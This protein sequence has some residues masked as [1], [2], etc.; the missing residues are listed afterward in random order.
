MKS[1]VL[2]STPFSALGF[3]LLLW[4]LPPL[5][6]AISS[7]LTAKPTSAL[8]CCSPI[9]ATLLGLV[10][11]LAAAIETFSIYRYQDTAVPSWTCTS[12]TILA[13]LA[14]ISNA[15]ITACFADA[16][17]SFCT[18]HPTRDCLALLAL[19]ALKLYVFSLALSKLGL[20][21]SYVFFTHLESVSW[22]LVV[23]SRLVFYSFTRRYLPATSSCPVYIVLSKHSGARLCV[24]RAQE[25]VPKPQK[26]EFIIADDW[27]L[28]CLFWFATTIPVSIW[29]VV[30]N[31]VVHS[32]Q[33][34]PFVAQLITKVE[35]GEGYQ[36]WQM[37]LSELRT[38]W[39]YI[40]FDV[41]PLFWVW[42]FVSFMVGLF[43]TW[44]RR[45]SA[46]RARAQ[47]V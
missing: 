3:M 8:L 5:A 27:G 39:L 34:A 41:A 31:W 33:A 28:F 1:T 23:G 12:L 37:L 20:G 29:N 18:S 6:F 10:V 46:V 9:Q 35:D 42:P 24:Q 17:T 32:Y 21:A 44:R 13:G 4:A 7:Q 26:G 22:L 15:K 11:L 30:R 16:D 47:E 25:G 45:R 19:L 40:L 14:G 2:D 43:F 36:A 38:K